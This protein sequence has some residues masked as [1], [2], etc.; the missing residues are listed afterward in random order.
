VTVEQIVRWG[1]ACGAQVLGFEGVGTL[2]VGQA[3]DFAVY[4]LDEP[5]YFG[6]HDP[7]IGPVVSGGRPTLK[8]L[9]ADGQVV[10][11]DDVL[12]N[13]DIAELQSSARAAVQ[14]L[15]QGI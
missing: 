13:V 10:V 9:V 2:E 15:V 3:A 11:Q 14:R 6:L 7:A 5:R 1:S 4:A 12:P 8:W